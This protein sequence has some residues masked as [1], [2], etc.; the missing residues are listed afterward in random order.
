MILT[1]VFDRVVDNEEYNHMT[2]DSLAI[3]FNVTLC[4]PPT[5]ASFDNMQHT[6]SLVKHCILHVSDMAVC[7]PPQ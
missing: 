6:L 5:L 3:C 4:K 7:P 2:P 1:T